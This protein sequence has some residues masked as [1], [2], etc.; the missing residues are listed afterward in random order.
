MIRP[1]GQRS[2]TLSPPIREA[3]LLLREWHLE[4]ED[5]AALVE[6]HGDP[7][8]ARLGPGRCEP[9][10]ASQKAA[11]RWI[12]ASYDLAHDGLGARM[13][14]CASGDRRVLGGLGIDVLGRDPHQLE[15]SF[16][17][18]AAQR[19][20]AVAVRALGAC[21]GWL[22]ESR[23]GSRLW[24]SVPTGDRISVATLH[25]CGF[26]EAWETPLPPGLQAQQSR[27]FECPLLPVG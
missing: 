17:V 11:R 6:G 1:V 19:R 26:S 16:W 22:A 15:V 20:Q 8:V 10:P 25:R 5:V 9:V 21:L 7:A 13:A 27:V 12:C 2:F 18:L 4:A 24:A 14:I 23:P 3:G